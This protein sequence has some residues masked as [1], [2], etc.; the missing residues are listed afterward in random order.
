VRYKRSIIVKNKDMAEFSKQYCEREMPELPG[1]FDI[2]EIAKSLT[3]NHYL[4]VICEGYGFIAVGLDEN[5]SIILAFGFSVG[6]SEY[7]VIWKPYEEVVV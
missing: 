7:S 4:P 1:D 3:K 6:D 5:E 2:L